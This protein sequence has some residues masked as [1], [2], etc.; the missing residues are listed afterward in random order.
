VAR[1]RAGVDLIYRRAALAAALD[2]GL[3]FEAA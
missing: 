2:L 3:D 1:S